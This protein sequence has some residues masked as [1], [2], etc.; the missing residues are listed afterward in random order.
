MK[1]VSNHDV[2]CEMVERGWGRWLIGGFPSG[3]SMSLRMPKMAEGLTYGEQS[4][5]C[6][7]FELRKR[8][9]RSELENKARGSRKGHHAAIEEYARGL[10]ADDPG[11]SARAAAE[12]AV[13]HAKSVWGVTVS[14]DALRKKIGTKKP[15]PTT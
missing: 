15:S 14:A 4:A 9:V 5:F 1:K 2:N 7:L 13:G 3:E 10:R 12:R 6:R 11:L 8:E